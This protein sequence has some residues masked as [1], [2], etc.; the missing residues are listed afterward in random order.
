MLWLLAHLSGGYARHHPLRAIVQ[1]IAI[2]VGVAL[3]YAINLINAS[4]LDEFSGAVRHVLGEADFSVSGGR[5][6]FDE[7]LYARIAAL[8]EVDTASPI[9]EVEAPVPTMPR[10][11]AG[12]ATLKVIGVDVFRAAQL[13]PALIG[14]PEAQDR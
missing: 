7:R 3:G 8:P 2:A 11:T 14:E 1:I 6:G 10:S 12:L 4:A 5:L 13:S 9:V